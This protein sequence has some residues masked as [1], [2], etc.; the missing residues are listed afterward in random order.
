M[1]PEPLVVVARGGPT[2]YIP[3]LLPPTGVVGG[4]PL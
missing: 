4:V 2:G 3:V 1:V